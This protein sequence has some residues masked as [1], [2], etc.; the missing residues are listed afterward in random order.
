MYDVAIIG[1][2]PAGIFC[3]LELI[4]SNPDL[5][6]IMLEKGK[7]IENRVCPDAQVSRGCRKC[8][9]CNV[10]T[11]WGGSGAF[12]DGKLI[13]STEIGGY[14]S[15]I[16]GKSNLQYLLDD[17][18]GIYRYYGALGHIYG[19]DENAIQEYVRKASM[20]GIEVIPSKVH[21]L[22]SD[23]C[24]N[25]MR[26]IYKA[27]SNKIEMLFETTVIDISRDEDDKTFHL[28]IMPA[29]GRSV[30]ARYLIAAPGRIGNGWLTDQA[31]ALGLEVGN[32]SVDIGIRV[33]VPSAIVED[34]TRVLYDPKLI[35]Y[36]KE[37]DDKVRM[38][39]CCPNGY[40]TTEY[41]NDVLTVNGQSFANKKSNNTNFALLVSIKFTAPFKEPIVYGKSIAKLANTLGDGVIVQRLYDL[42]QGKRST[43]ER[44][45]RNPI[46]P[47]LPSACPGDLSFV[48][49]YRYLCSIMEMLDVLNKLCPGINNAGTLLYGMEVKF[50]SSRL[51]V[52]NNLETGIENLYAIGDG[53]GITRGLTQAS[54]SGIVA[55]RSILEKESLKVK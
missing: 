34:L 7:R 32:N 47:T 11:G 9:P 43:P 46:K 28:A 1:S 40:V 21:H 33:E 26:N 20:L 48:I 12:S 25:V 55:A 54:A 2:G 18:D 4:R 13:Y 16:I 42:Q 22:G 6:I 36:S 50:Y 15:D 14:L 49:P 39:C 8:D 41:Y 37:F 23:G 44:I 27:L 3:A 35:Y 24:F 29:N 5:K 38:F 30:N 10:L 17:V 45:S 52:N 53:A 31:E 19:T 51:Q